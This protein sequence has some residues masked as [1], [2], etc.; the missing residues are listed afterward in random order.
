MPRLPR[1]TS[2]SQSSPEL[3]NRRA[4]PTVTTSLAR[5]RS[6]WRPEWR[7]GPFEA[8]AS[9]WVRKNHW[10]ASHTL[11]DREDAMAECALVFAKC[12]D[13][14]ILNPDKGAKPGYKQ[15]TEPAHFMALFKTAL[16]YR[17]IRLQEE[18]AAY[19]SVIDSGLSADAIIAAAE[20]PDYEHGKQGRSAPVSLAPRIENEGMLAS[21]VAY[22]SREL[23][24]VLAV[25]LAAPDDVVQ[26]ITADIMG[27]PLRKANRQRIN[28]RIQRM[29]GL[30]H[31]F[32]FIGELRELVA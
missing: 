21:A 24:H 9:N 11:P 23:R 5:Y 17:W 26:A 4:A 12:L 6:P 18:E 29:L 8:Y 20:S 15:V 2:V 22:S 14:Y 7:G 10:R 19:N 25:M 28:S 32:D 13:R 16:Y 30:R 27:D 3:P 31:S 1:R